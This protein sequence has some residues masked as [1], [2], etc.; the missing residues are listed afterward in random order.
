LQ[1]NPDDRDSRWTYTA[2]CGAEGA[3]AVFVVGGAFLS[4]E[5]FEPPYIVA[6]IAI[7]LWSIVRTPPAPVASITEYPDAQYA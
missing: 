5:T 6:M 7:Q 3:L 2:A 4:L 1:A